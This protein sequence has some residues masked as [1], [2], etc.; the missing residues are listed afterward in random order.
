MPEQDKQQQQFAGIQS[1]LCKMTS[2]TGLVAS[3]TVIPAHIAGEPSSEMQNEV[4]KPPTVVQHSSVLYFGQ[5]QGQ[6]EGQQE[7]NQENDEGKDDKKLGMNSIVTQGL[8][9]QQSNADSQPQS[10]QPQMNQT[11]PEETRTDNQDVSGQQVTQAESESMKLPMASQGIFDQA[12]KSEQPNQQLQ[13]NA[14]VQ[15][16]QNQNNPQN[17]FPPQALMMMQ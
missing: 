14:N 11:N 1:Q 3:N 8:Q 9:L 15:V 5:K 12:N 2:T 17:Q 6:F 13:D 16:Q 10:Q 4:Q 7:E